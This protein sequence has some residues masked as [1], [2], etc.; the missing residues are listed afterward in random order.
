M[1]RLFLAIF[2]VVVGLLL[3]ACAAT[4]TLGAAQA[5][6]TIDVKSSAQTVAPRTESYSATSFGNYEFRAQAPGH[7]PFYGVLP[8]KFNG[9]YLA[10]DILFF[11]PAMF[12]NLREVYPFYNFDVEKKVVKY[13]YKEGDEWSTYVPLDA[14]MVRAREFFSAK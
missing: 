1:R 7:E 9:G 2:A 14:E 6:A 8:L 4:T 11:A 3:S 5:G 12:F 10:V 13:R